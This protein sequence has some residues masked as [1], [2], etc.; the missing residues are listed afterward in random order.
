MKY[1]IW[2]SRFLLVLQKISSSSSSVFSEFVRRGEFAMNEDQR[3]LS[4]A[5]YATIGRKIAQKVK[6]RRTVAAVLKAQ[7]ETETRKEE[8]A[9]QEITKIEAVPTKW[10]D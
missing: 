2:K 1:W 8:M 3:E 7:F 10:L 6:M 4:M 5:E 9:R